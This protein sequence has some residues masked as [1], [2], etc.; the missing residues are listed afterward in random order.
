MNANKGK[1]LEGLRIV[2]AVAAKDIVD[3]IKNKTTISIMIGVAFLMLSGQALPLLMKL[4]ATP[5]AVVYDAGKSHLIAEL[6]KGRD[7][8]LRPVSSLQ[9]LTKTVAESTGP[10]LGLA[11]PADM[12]ARL[13]AGEPVELDG[14]LAHWLDPAEASEARVFFQERLTQLAGQ[15]VRINVE[16]HAV[17]PSPDSG[18]QASMITMS[19]VTAVLA[20]CGAIVPFLM[21][22]EK[23]THTLD[24]LLVSPA[25]IGQVVT[26]KAL[27]GL[28]YGLTV[29]GVVLAFNLR[30][31]VHWEVAVLATVCGSLF[32]VAIGLLLGSLF[33]NP[34]SMNLCFGGVL[35]ILIMPVFL[36]GALGLNA[37][38]AVRAILPWVPSVLWADVVRATFAQSVPWGQVGLNLGVVSGWVVLLLALVAWRVRRSDR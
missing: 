6:G 33:D 5:N 16:G 9:E 21:I 8:R 30:M 38:Q 35:L 15:T 4:R 18:G 13:E 36:T 20:I 29:A 2:W 12:D 14:Y 1:L 22:E 26:G 25:S 37:P 3:A 32:A 23:E 17:Y 28:F 27:A 11:V 10:V 34:G 7:L 31:V 19:L 24:A